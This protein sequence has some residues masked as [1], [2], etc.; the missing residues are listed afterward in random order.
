MSTKIT[1]ENG[2]FQDAAG[3]LLANGTLVL[4]LSNDAVTNDAS[5]ENQI[6]G[7][8]PILVTLDSNGNVKGTPKIWSNAELTPL[9]TYYSATAFTASGATAWRNTQ[10][11]VFS[12]SGGSTVDLGTMVPTSASV[13][14]S[15]SV[16]TSPS[17][18][19]TILSNNLLPASGNTTQSL[20][21]L[22]APWDAV[23]NTLTAKT[24][25]FTG[26][27]PWYDVRSYGA[28]MDGVTDDTI[29]VQAA[30]TAANAAG[31]GVVFIPYSANP[32]IIASQ[33]VLDGFAQVE[34]RGASSGQYLNS[35]TFSPG[36]LKFT[37][38]PAGAQ[39]SCRSTFG[40][41]LR[42]LFI[43]N[44]N[45]SFTG[46]IV[47]T[48]HSALATDTQAFMLDGCVVG[49]TSTATSAAACVGLDKAIVSTLK[50]SSFR[51]AALGLR[52]LAAAGSYSNAIQVLSCAFGNSNLFGTSHISNPGAGWLISGCTFEIAY[53]GTN[54]VI[55]G[56]GATSADSG[57]GST[58]T[59]CWFGDSG[60]GW[61][62]SIFYQIGS[63]WS[64][65][66][67]A[68]TGSPS[69][70]ATVYT[71]GA[72]DSGISITGNTINSFGTGFVFNATQVGIVIQ[73]N[74]IV[75]VTSVVSG[76]A[77]SG[78]ICQDAGGVYT[79]NGTN[80]NGTA[81]TIMGTTSTTGG[82]DIYRGVAGVS[83]LEM[84]YCN[85]SNGNVTAGNLHVQ[86]LSSGLFTGTDEF[87]VNSSG[88]IATYK[89]I[90]TAGNGVPAEV[91]QLLSSGLT[92]N[93][94]SGS[95][96]TLFTPT[97]PGQWRISF[98]EAITQ[99]ATSSS[100]MPSLVLGWT[101]AAGIARTKTIVATSAANT[102][103]TESDGAAIIYTNGSTAVTVTSAS[104]ASS[105]GTPMK[106]DI[107]VTA[108]QL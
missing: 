35:S 61:T 73:S 4:Q 74:S 34:I 2:G 79:L 30:L 86:G 80:E 65:T 69:T 23:L 58:I 66:G 97:T 70:G 7:N 71:F 18:D 59:G 19:Q 11:W 78:L 31:G 14:Y 56:S 21:S 5:P 20:G 100:T 22:A 63:G 93:Y 50:N 103:A 102:T 3:N 81:L 62:G 108:E 67:N 68:I 52:G 44:T 48:S 82:L 8:V 95:A 15:G 72:N 96:K 28:V 1:L 60:T 49:G 57:Q 101:D 53:T 75:S 92:A 41:T 77:K 76:A 99:A 9:G 37:G 46:M 85:P 10:S 98:S 29:A 91:L 36:Y 17:G 94:N 106:Y 42:N 25:I 24:P 84:L 107:S 6:C 104:Y 55:D 13:S 40:V 83:A 12:Q 26:P 88:V 39:I 64:I 33:L 54:N 27:T 89:G 105:G 16:L 47:D 45:A 32:C 87:L 38:N 90:A 43:Q 51:Y